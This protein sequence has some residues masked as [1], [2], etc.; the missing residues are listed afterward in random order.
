MLE[1]EIERI[2]PS[3]SSLR[4]G[5]VVRY[6]DNG[7]VRFAQARIDWD[8]FTPEVMGELLRHIDRLRAQHLDREP[9]DALPLTWDGS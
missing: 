8:L 2:S 9:D 6:G 7:P 5:L 1:V 4:V 3:P